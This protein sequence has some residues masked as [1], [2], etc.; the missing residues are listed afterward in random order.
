MAMRT[1]DIVNEKG[2]HARASAKFV[3]TVESFDAR[4]EVRRDGLSAVGDSIMGLLMLAASKGTSIE[5][6]T[7]GNQAD[8]LMD[9]LAALVADKFGEE[10]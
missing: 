7:S 9:A 8:L 10:Y 3:E 5:V 1:L 2:L 4:A 6:E